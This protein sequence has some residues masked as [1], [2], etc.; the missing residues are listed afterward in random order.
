MTSGDAFLDR[1]VA[2][3][4]TRP[5]VEAVLQSGSRVRPDGPVDAYS[6]YDVEL[7]TRERERYL[8]TDWLAEIAPVMV[9][10]ALDDDPEHTSRLVF[11]AD[12][13]KVDY[14]VMD[15]DLLERLERD[16]LDELHERG[17]RVLHDPNGRAARLPAA[18][19][20]SPVHPPPAEAEFDFTCRE[21]W[22][23]AAHIPRSL[24]RGEPW[25]VKFRD[26]TMKE[27]L[28]RMLEWHALA[29]SGDET[30]VWYIGT[31]LRAWVA[32]DVLARLDAVFGRFDAE[33]ARR[34][35]DATTALFAELSAV[36]ARRYGFPDPSAIGDP[37]QAYIASFERRR[38]ASEPA[39]AAASPT[40]ATTPSAP[41]RQTKP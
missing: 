27:D 16:G 4:A 6:D 35:L 7:Y 41:S 29:T 28:L 23:E 9:H 2:W 36:V 31:K 15:V 20:R 22:F 10:L 1:I 37:V 30:D 33:D 18:T 40:P 3:A 5:D 12:G 39:P 21:F 13:T 14:Q 38:S 26:W 8:G 24:A 34:A 19:H 11:Y 32:P 25:V 17:Y